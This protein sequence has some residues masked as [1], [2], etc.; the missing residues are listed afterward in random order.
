MIKK[1]IKKYDLIEIKTY[2][3]LMIC[4]IVVVGFCPLRSQTI[5]QLLSDSIYTAYESLETDTAKITYLLKYVKE[6]L[7]NDPK[8]SL[9][10]LK[11]ADLLSAE[12]DDY[13][14]EVI[15]Y[16]MARVYFQIT[17]MDSV[18]YWADQALIY[19]DS[20]T[21]PQLYGLTLVLLSNTMRFLS[22][23]VQAQQYRQRAQYHL[24]LARDTTG[25]AIVYNDLGL[26]YLCCFYRTNGS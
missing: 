2:R 7:P 11:V 19:T 21:S 15:A 23:D 14:K 4:A 20:L 16:S 12:R 13:K 5:E 10:L 24:E 22:N 8:A 25:L 26:Y 1:L 9:P 3:F 6:E 17:K 18:K